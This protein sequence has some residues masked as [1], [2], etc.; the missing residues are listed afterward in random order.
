MSHVE[1]GDLSAS[2]PDLLHILSS[3]LYRQP[4]VFLRELCANSFDALMRRFGALPSKTALPE[5]HI[6]CVDERTV[7]IEDEGIGM[8]RAE[9]EGFLSCIG[10]SASRLARARGMSTIGR[11]GMGFLSVLAVAESVW[12][13]TCAERDAVT[14]SWQWFWQATDH[15][16]Y[17]LQPLPRRRVGTRVMVLLR[18]DLRRYADC[19]VVKLLLQTHVPFLP[20]PLRVSAAPGEPGVEPRSWFPPWLRAP[21]GK[22]WRFRPEEKPPFLGGAPMYCF[23]A[24]LASGAGVVL[25]VPSGAPDEPRGVTLCQYGVLVAEQLER[26]L[27]AGWQWLYAFIDSTETT[28]TLDRE[29]VLDDENLQQLQGE[30]AAVLSEELVYLSTH[31]SGMLRRILKRHRRSLCRLM[32][33]DAALREHIG[34]AYLLMTTRGE[35]T[36]S[37]LLA[38]AAQEPGR[39]ML[40]VLTAS[41]LADMRWGSARARGELIVHC[42]DEQELTLLRCMLPRGFALTQLE[43]GWTSH[44]GR[45]TPPVPDE[46]KPWFERIRSHLAE[47]HILVEPTHLLADELLAVAELPASGELTGR[48][49]EDQRMQA[50]LS[51]F[52]KDLL[53]NAPAESTYGRL[54]VN[55]ASPRCRVLANLEDGE[56]PTELQAALLFTGGALRSGVSVPATWNAPLEQLTARGVDALVQ[57]RQ[58]ALS[59][60]RHTVCFFAHE[61]SSRNRRLRQLLRRLVEHE[62]YF[63]EL[64]SA[65]EL[66]MDGELYGNVEKHLRKSDVVLCEVTD[67]NKNVMLEMG[68][69]MGM[70]GSSVFLLADQRFSVDA[71]DL[72]SRLLLYYDAQALDEAPPEQRAA[73]E[74]ELFLKLQHFLAHAPA[75]NRVRGRAPFLGY[76]LLREAGLIDAAEQVALERVIGEAVNLLPER[77]ADLARQTAIPAGR[78]MRI[79]Q[80]FQQR[81]E[82]FAAINGTVW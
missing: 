41:P 37:D 38:A 5:L 29:S 31:D 11:F 71:A 39:P 65:D 56:C 46:L 50:A 14:E 13:E 51:Q 79:Q 54:M 1:V 45:H 49:D 32:L 23:S 18:S 58:T 52:M 26:V 30:L 22:R 48:V 62:P 44:I 47:H 16:R 43:Y 74:E 2:I 3:F 77:V 55:L 4:E 33:S 40:R 81:I 17:L 27:P 80:Y 7:M 76:R 6:T 64:T 67:Y 10:R 78:I 9:L 36:I 61:Y 72:R 75:L 73:A 19:E 35:L 42:L 57:K 25:G 82:K 70:G 15:N 60:S 59:R 69:A 12:V 24:K 53:V 21:A 8:T 63:W 68:M 66:T 28:L 34:G 20:V